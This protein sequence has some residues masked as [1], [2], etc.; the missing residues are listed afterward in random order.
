MTIVS[1]SG[2]DGAGKTTQICALQ[3]WLHEVGLTSRLLTFW[4]DVVVAPQ[5]REA[6]S[7]TAFKGDQGIGSPEKPLHR[8]DKNVTS[9]TVTAMRF[10]LYFADALNLR[11]KIGQ[12]KISQLK[13]T[14]PDVI[15]FDRYI[16]DELA[17]LPLNSRLVRL[18]IHLVLKLAPKPDIAYVIDAVPDSAFQRKPEY[19]LEFL[20]ENRE[21]YHALSRLTGHLT[22][23][24]PLSIEAAKLRIKEVFL[25]QVSRPVPGLS[26]AP[27]PE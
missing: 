3:N 8:R 17:N 4:D 5:F 27:A 11:R 1:F 16:Y 6:A 2:I 24:E 26:E 10:L 15:I 25:Q 20:R 22:V 13:K 14:D 19:P 12:L 9:R 18:Y 23:I 21:A 7:R